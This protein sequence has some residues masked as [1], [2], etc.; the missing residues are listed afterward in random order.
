MERL[1]TTATLAAIFL[2]ALCFGSGSAGDGKEKMVPEPNML[3][4]SGEKYLSG[5]ID[6]LNLTDSLAESRE[7]PPV[8]VMFL[9]EVE[10][11]AGLPA[12]VRQCL[13]ESVKFPEFAR[14]KGLEGVVVVSMFFDANGNIRIRDSYSNDESLRNY[15]LDRIR[16]VQPH[17]CMVCIGKEYVVRFLFRII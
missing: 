14:E 4:V 5:I 16:S 17:S 7:D 8:I 11:T 15:V 13:F 3:A 6:G 1:K 10:I 12:P 2:A 9:E